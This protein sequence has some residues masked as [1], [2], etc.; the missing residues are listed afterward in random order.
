MA[1][2]TTDDSKRLG[3]GTVTVLTFDTAE[4][5]IRVKTYDTYTGGYR[6]DSAEQY[7]FGMFPPSPDITQAPDGPGPIKTNDVPSVSPMPQFAVPGR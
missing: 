6:T 5:T 3:G 2:P 4:N 7:A 1:S